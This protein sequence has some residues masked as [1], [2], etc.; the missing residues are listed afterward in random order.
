[1]R[2][3]GPIPTS[4]Y[5][6]PQQWLDALSKCGYRAAF[7]PVPIGAS[8]ADVASYR[9]AAKAGD[10][11]IAEVGAWSNP[12]SPDPETRH[13]ALEKCKKSLALAEAIGARCSVNVVGSLGDK[14]DGPDPR[15]V[16]QGA[17]DRIVTTL[18]EIID[19]VAPQSALWT[20]EMM[21]RML[22]DSADSYVELIDAIDRPALGVHFDP[23][24]IINSPRRYYDTGAVIRDCFAKLGP[25]IVS[26][27]AKD[28]VLTGDLTVHLD[29][30]RPGTGKLDYVTFLREL[31]ALDADTPLML[32]HL[33]T[34]D[35]YAKAA[36]HIRSIA[37][38]E[39]V[40]L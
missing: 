31:D 2:L 23:V 35:E 12:M 36:D 1:M 5:A 34:Q 33:A 4:A 14:W 28:I 6:T 38:Q 22:P 18:Q 19:A 27:H 29:E 15:D 40:S 39:G 10:I 37:D 11:V 7:C 25:R 9:E 32:E 26:C 20:I 21:P 13:A 8:D 30:C 17:F 3:G 16:T 24:N